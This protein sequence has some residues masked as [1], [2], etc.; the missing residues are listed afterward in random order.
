MIHQVER[1][2][3]NEEY[4]LLRVALRIWYELVPVVLPYCLGYV[5]DFTRSDEFLDCWKYSIFVDGIR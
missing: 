5:F 3:K 2:G 4:S 1:F